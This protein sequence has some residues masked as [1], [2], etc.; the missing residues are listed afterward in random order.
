M[1]AIR[2]LEEIP[3][4][5]RDDEDGNEREMHFGLQIYIYER[6]CFFDTGVFCDCGLVYNNSSMN[7]H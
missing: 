3:E 6:S 4:W 2:Y 1:F 5:R 7:D